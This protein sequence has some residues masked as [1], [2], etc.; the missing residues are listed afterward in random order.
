MHG[1]LMFNGV[2][3]Q[4]ESSF[5]QQSLRNGSLVYIHDHSNSKRDHFQY[6][7][8]VGDR[9][10]SSFEFTIIVNSVDDDPPVVTFIQDPLFVVELSDVYINGSALVIEDLDSESDVEF[11]DIVCTVVTPPRYGLFPRSR[12]G[13]ET[14][15]TSVFTKYDIERNQLRYNHISLGH[16]EDSFTFSI[17]DGINLQDEIYEVRIVILPNQ[18]SIRVHNISTTYAGQSV[19]ITKE[20]FI[21]DH[22]YLSNVP[23]LFIIIRQPSNGIL[24][25]IVTNKRISHFTTGDLTDESIIYHHN[26]SLG[27]ALH[28]SFDF[29]YESLQPEGLHRRSSPITVYIHLLPITTVNTGFAVLEGHGYNITT[30]ELNILSFNTSNRLSAQFHIRP[31]NHGDIMVNNEND[32][33]SFD[34]SD[35]TTGLIYY[36]NNGDE[37][38]QDNLE[39]SIVGDYCIPDAQCNQI[40]L[41]DTNQTAVCSCS[42]QVKE[43]L[44]QHNQVT[45]TRQSLSKLCQKHWDRREI[46]CL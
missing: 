45:R 46:F 16:Y 34:L 36:Q 6:E 3:L 41:S 8:S 9:A 44:F 38:L 29:F 10:K 7:L 25:N 14:R 12:F 39:F 22:P 24:M 37:Y 4:T 23:G 40:Q 1:S 19:Y 18:I 32:V 26:V 30:Q 20:D 2:T 15:S 42:S 28:D 21:I 27:N 17:T 13:T 35:L 11:D 33:T 5:D 31:P 43:F